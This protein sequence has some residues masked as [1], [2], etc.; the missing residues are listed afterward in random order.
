MI[1]DAASHCPRSEFQVFCYSDIPE[2]LASKA[3]TTPNLQVVNGLEAILGGVHGEW[4]P[5]TDPP[6][7]LWVEDQFA[8]RDFTHL[9]AHLARSVTREVEPETILHELLKTTITKVEPSAE[10][11]DDA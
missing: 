3:L 11:K 5:P 2:V 6:P 9:A 8:L 7:G 1:F 10:K 4:E